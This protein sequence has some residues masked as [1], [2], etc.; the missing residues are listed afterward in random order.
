MKSNIEELKALRTQ[1]QSQSKSQQQPVNSNPTNEYVAIDVSKR[2]RE[3]EEAANTAVQGLDN[4]G[5]SNINSVI[6]R[7]QRVF[8]SDVQAIKDSIKFYMS[9]DAKL[10]VATIQAAQEIS[11]ESGLEVNVSL[12]KFIPDLPEVPVLPSYSRFYASSDVQQVRQLGVG[13]SANEPQN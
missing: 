2:I 8:A 1:Q 10:A 6:A 11:A 5:Y 7:R 4:A 12:G 3:M 9:P 13:S